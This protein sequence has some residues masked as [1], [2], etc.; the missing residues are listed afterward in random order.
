MIAQSG[1]TRGL[2]AVIIVQAEE[3]LVGVR[4]QPAEHLRGG[5]LGVKVGRLRSHAQCVM[6]AANLHAFATAFAEIAHEDGEQ[7]A[8]AGVLLLYAAPNGGNIVV[9]QR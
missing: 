3:F 6:I 8:V 2:G 7:A 5:K 4:Q 9:R 1:F